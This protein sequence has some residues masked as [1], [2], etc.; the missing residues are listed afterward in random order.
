MLPES[1]R[2]TRISRLARLHLIAAVVTPLTIKNGLKGQHLAAYPAVRNRRWETPQAE[3]DLRISSW[4]KCS[5]GAQ[6]SRLD[7]ARG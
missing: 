7:T 6:R 1:R 3:L 4:G 5:L 2:L